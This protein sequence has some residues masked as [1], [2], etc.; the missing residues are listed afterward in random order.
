MDDLIKNDLSNQ[1]VFLKK[2]GSGM[3]RGFEL[4]KI[5]VHLILL[6]LS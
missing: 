1:S 4:M 3:L 5:L 6:S 2:K